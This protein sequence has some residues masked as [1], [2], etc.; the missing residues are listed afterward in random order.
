MF[1][2]WG[3]VRINILEYIALGDV[4]KNAL[5]PLLY[6]SIFLIL[7]MIIG[8][9]F[10]FPM[11]MA[12][13]DSGSPKLQNTKYK[14]IILS[15]IGIVFLVPALYISLFE[16]GGYRWH[17]VAMLVSLPLVLLIGRAEFARGYIAD[18]DKR[19]L[20]VNILCV[21][22]VHAYGW[23][24][25]NAISAKNSSDTIEVNG[26][27]SE[28]KYLGWAGDFLFLWDGKNEKVVIKSKSTI[29]TLVLGSNSR[30]SN[31]NDSKTQG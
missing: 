14:W 30:K 4:V 17:K 5:Y 26:K 19:V 2:Y 7:G 12:S 16:T 20:V 11:R 21:F 9:L 27:T 8:N 23:G 22:L 1:G 24:A 28:H 10:I 25:R 29:E 13:A 15:V 3:E 18:A 6:S 31:S